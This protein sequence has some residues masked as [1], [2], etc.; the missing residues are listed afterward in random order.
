MFLRV[1]CDRMEAV[2]EMNINKINALFDTIVE[3][4]KYIKRTTYKMNK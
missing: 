3:D 4:V 1:K 2:R